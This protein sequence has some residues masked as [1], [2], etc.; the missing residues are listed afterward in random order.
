M[1]INI[2]NFGLIYYFFNSIENCSKMEEEELIK[3][4]NDEILD[5]LEKF[6]KFFKGI[7]NDIQSKKDQDD[8]NTIAELMREIQSLRDEIHFLTHFLKLPKQIIYLVDEYREP[9]D[10]LIEVMEELK[11]NHEKIKR[12][13]ENFGLFSNLLKNE[14]R[15]SEEV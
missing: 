9:E 4:H 3:K 12:K 8:S 14:I 10:Y 2:L 13:E 15:E 5:K 6:K 7:K 11:S 1:E